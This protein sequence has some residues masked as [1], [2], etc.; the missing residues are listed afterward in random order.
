MSHRLRVRTGARCVAPLPLRHTAIYGAIDAELRSGL[1][2]TFDPAPRSA[3]LPSLALGAALSLAAFAPLDAAQAATLTVTTTDVTIAVDAVCSLP[4]AVQNANDNAATNVDCAA[5]DAGLDTIE[6]DPT[7]V[8]S[9]STITL[10][11]TLGVIDALAITG[12]GRDALTITKSN[13]GSMLYSYAPLSVSGLHFA[14]GEADVGAAIFTQSSLNVSA[15][16]F[17]GN[18]AVIGGAIAGGIKYDGG[19]RGAARKGA[20]VQPSEWILSDVEFIGNNAYAY[21]A[22]FA[23]GG[24]VAMLN[25]PNPNVV[26]QLDVV[27]S[28][29]QGNSAAKY[30]AESYEAFG[31]GLAVFDDL[32]GSGPGFRSDVELFDTDFDQNDASVGGGAFLSASSVS[33]QGGSFTANEALYGG[34]LIVSAGSKYEPPAPRPRLRPKTVL[35]TDSTVVIGG[36][37]IEGN[38]AVYAAGGAFVAAEAGWT[39]DSVSVT[40]NSAGYLG[41][42]LLTLSKYDAGNPAVVN[43]LSGSTLA[44]NSAQIGGGWMLNSDVDAIT[45]A[46]N[47]TIDSNQA[48]D[49]AGRAKG[50]AKG[51]AGAGYGGGVLAADGQVAF[52]FVTLTRNTAGSA[53]GGLQVGNGEVSLRNSIVA[54]NSAT[55]GPDIAGT[56]NADFTLVQDDTDATLVGADNDV[57]SDPLLGALADN[58][59]PTETRLPLFGSPVINTGDPAFA[60]PPDFDQR[61]SG[62]PRAIATVDKGAVEAPPTIVSIL[63]DPD[64]F[65]EG[66]TSNLT[67]TLS[68]VATQDVLVTVDFTGTA[69]LDTD[70]TADDADVAAG[71]QVAIPIGS[72]SGTI[73]LDALADATDE[74]DEPFTA[75]FTAASGAE[76]QNGPL[77]DD[78]VI[79]DADPTPTIAVNDV[80]VAETGASAGYTVS[81][82]NASSQTVSVDYQTSDGSAVA[83]GDYTAISGTLDFAP[84]QTSL[85]LAVTV[86]ADGLDEPDETFTLELSGALNAAI[87]DGSGLGTITDSNAPPTV[88]LGI[89]PPQINEGGAGTTITLTLSGPSGQDVIVTLIFSGTAGFGTDYTVPDADPITPGVQVVIP[90]GQ[91]SASVILTALVDGLAE[92]N[93]SV[94]VDIGSVVNGVEAGTAQASATI[95]GSGGAVP[96]AQ[97]ALIPTLSQWMLVLLGL[98]LPATVIARFRRS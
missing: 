28:L 8:P 47:T 59:G 6:F 20:L 57:G 55:G 29:F 72:S 75:T 26:P 43:T 54:E 69:I 24:A 19:N 56:V 17:S 89:A 71:I 11:D 4:E 42:G 84:G 82:S 27:D 13:V 21:A 81:L 14:D 50:R 3:C 67:V 70:F 79:L 40:D 38:Y 85:P 83:P 52:E 76:I 61:G 74:P 58:G 91:T 93:E 31:G 9:G 73:V 18:T 63:I 33:I 44:R 12:P 62:F 60:P 1:G 65:A 86:V 22:P 48:T 80:I 87:G 49:I 36:T 97:P 7:E 5:G 94:I 45:R 2:P 53:G 16:R 10:D 46:V 77:S 15:S 90:A 95:L 92:G 78:A 25:Q 37:R 64:P 98:L 35:L 88:T 66:A 96:V 34:G 32:S 30:G 51:P 39:L 23:I 41:G 68:G